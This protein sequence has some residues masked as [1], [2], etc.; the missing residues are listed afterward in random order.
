MDP[1]MTRYARQSPQPYQYFLEVIYLKLNQAIW[2]N[3]SILVQGDD[4]LQLN[5]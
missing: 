2:F 3:Q 4:I 1:D 5:L